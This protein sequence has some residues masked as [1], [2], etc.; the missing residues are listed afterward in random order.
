MTT[1]NRQLLSK[2]GEINNLLTHAFTVDIVPLVLKKTYFAGHTFE[3]KWKI[4]KTKQKAQTRKSKAE[5]RKGN[6]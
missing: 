2:I 3:Y 1:F 4:N 6:T 5:M